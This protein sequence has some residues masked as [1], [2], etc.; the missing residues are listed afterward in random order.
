MF[1]LI[2]SVKALLAGVL[3]LCAGSLSV[4]QTSPNYEEDSR[5]DYAAARQGIR[6]FEGAL[7]SA[8]NSTF[9]SN[10]FALVNKPKGV[11][12]QGYGLSFNFLIN[13]HN[14][15]ITPFG[16]IKSPSS[17]PELKKRRIEDLKERLTRLLLDNGNV[18]K[19]IKR[20]DTITIVAFFED[21]NFPDE[22][23]ENKTVVISVF[24]KDLDDLA[25]RDDRLREFK[26]RIRIIEY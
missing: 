6:A 12:L 22:P 19:Q 18:F 7:Y 13:I 24:K 16:E 11:Y 8:I 14:A 3:L 21:R 1:D 5:V 25:G 9:N 4:G 23:N 17:T 26:Q 20:D 15:V 10:S 2:R